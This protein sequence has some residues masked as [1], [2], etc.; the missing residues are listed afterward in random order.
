MP[1]NDTN[2]LP[3]AAGVGTKVTG[4]SLPKGEIDFAT[5][6]CGLVVFAAVVV[7]MVARQ[8]ETM[9]LAQFVSD[10]TAVPLDGITMVCLVAVLMSIATVIAIDLA[11]FRRY[12]S[13]GAHARAGG[14]IRTA[15]GRIAK[16]L[17]ALYVVFLVA[18]LIY[19][20]FPEYGD[21]YGRFFDVVALLLPIIVVLAVPYFVIVDRTMAEPE[22]GYFHTANLLIGLAL[23]RRRFPY[24]WRYVYDLVMGWVVKLFFLP[25]MFSYLTYEVERLAEFDP[26][27]LF[28]AR[29]NLYD[30]MYSFLYAVDLVFATCGY[31]MTLKLTNSHIKSTDPTVFGWLVCLICYQPFASIVFEQYLNYENGVFWGQWLAENTIVYSAWAALIIVMIT[32]YS[33]ASVSLG[34]R[35]SNVTYRGLATSGVYRLTKHPAYVS[36][37]ISW[38][39]ISIPFVP[40]GDLFQAGKLCLMMLGVNVLYYLRARTE[41]NHLSNYPEYVAYANWMNEHGMFAWLGRLIPYLKYS[42]SRAKRAN[43]VVWWRKPVS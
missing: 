11:V 39:L 32:L 34:F 43:S 37:N 30:F 31:I 17:F 5:N 2:S 28:D 15:V 26:A 29:A 7:L 13:A 19:A 38:W 23:G 8:D 35:F 22:D 9:A 36:K 12:R 4:R 18:G 10:M 3:E 41:E 21:F 16:K 25:L 42:E 27:L 14:R 6:V 20:S 1:T 40:A 33:L 24:D